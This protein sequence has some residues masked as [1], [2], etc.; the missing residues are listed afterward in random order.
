VIWWVPINHPLH[1]E[2]H[3]DALQLLF[4]DAYVLVALMALVGVAVARISTPC[5]LVSGHSPL[6]RARRFT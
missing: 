2:L 1:S 6:T 3:L 4:A 5:I